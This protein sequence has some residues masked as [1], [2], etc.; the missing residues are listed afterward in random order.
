MNNIAM[1]LGLDLNTFNVFELNLG[2]WIQFNSIQFNLT[3]GLK[4]NWIELKFNY[5][6]WDAN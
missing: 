2:I 3:N 1:Q 4:C 5:R 6:K